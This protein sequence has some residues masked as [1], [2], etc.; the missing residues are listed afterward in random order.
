MILETEVGIGSYRLKLKIGKAGNDCLSH[1]HKKEI[2][3][4]FQKKSADLLKSSILNYNIL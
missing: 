4:L 2:Q 3:V 1:G